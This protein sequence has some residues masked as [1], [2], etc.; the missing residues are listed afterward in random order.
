MPRKTLFADDDVF[1]AVGQLMAQ[2]GSVTTSAV[3]EAAKLSTGSLYHRFGSREGLL[4]ET[5][6]FALQAFQPH[7]VNAL[8]TPNNPVGEIAAVTP[9]FCRQHR[10]EAL[11]LAC[12][13]YR[14][15]IN[16]DT[17]AAIRQCIDEANAKTFAAF[18]SY[19]KRRGFNLDACRMALITFPLS[20]VKQYL[21][22][23]GVPKEVDHI[24]A[25]AAEAIL[26]QTTDYKSRFLDSDG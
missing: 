20:A 2:Q 24:V 6:L 14:Q 21:P 1:G 5:W 26:S 22:E 18:N 16:D 9:R 12:C 11:I 7:F 10:R 13:N 25:V 19:V 15:F 8:E 23:N 4:A 17:P 3:Q